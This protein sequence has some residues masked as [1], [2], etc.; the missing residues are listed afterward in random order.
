MVLIIYLTQNNLTAGK[1]HDK[2]YRPEA[3][4]H[5]NDPYPHDPKDLPHTLADYLGIVNG[6]LKT[7]PALHV[8]IRD[9]V[10]IVAAFTADGPVTVLCLTSRAYHRE[11]YTIVTFVIV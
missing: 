9:A 10:H 7:C 2:C 5:H 4:D 3:Q 6:T 8:L 1:I 11:Y